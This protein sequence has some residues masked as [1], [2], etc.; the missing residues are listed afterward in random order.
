MLIGSGGVLDNLPISEDALS[1]CVRVHNEYNGYRMTG[2]FFATD[3]NSNILLP[4]YS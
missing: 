1:L 2:R 3:T 4:I